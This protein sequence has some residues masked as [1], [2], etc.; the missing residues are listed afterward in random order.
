MI[1]AAVLMFGAIQMMPVERTN[2]PVES[3]L[4][5]PEEIAAILEKACYDCHSNKTRWPWYSY[6]APVSWYLVRHVQ[7]AR[8]D[9]NFSEWP[10]FDL[11][12]ESDA[13]RDIHKQVSRGKMP[14]KS[15]KIMHRGA[16]LSRKEREILLRWA[17]EQQ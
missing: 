6:V 16:R 2:P 14:L 7:R 13:L 12:L 3:E 15:Y 8:S 10:V 5:V 9:L 17:K 4:Q 11:E 1:L